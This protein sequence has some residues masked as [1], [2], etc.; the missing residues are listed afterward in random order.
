MSQRAVD[1]NR[2]SPL[3]VQ[4]RWAITQWGSIQD[5]LR[6]YLLRAG[7]VP[8]EQ[9]RRNILA[10][11]PTLIRYAYS[12]D[13]DDFLVQSVLMFIDC[14]TLEMMTTSQTWVKDENVRWWACEAVVGQYGMA[15]ERDAA[16][17]KRR[18]GRD[19]L[20]ACSRVSQSI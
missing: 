17:C 1:A 7:G 9:T 10:L 20:K 14:H 16:A 3:I 19:G 4:L 8:S 6:D 12:L 11:H 18:A 2:I 13:P 5:H 15:E